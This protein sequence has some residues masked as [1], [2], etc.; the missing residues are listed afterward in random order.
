MEIIADELTVKKPQQHVQQISKINVYLSINEINIQQVIW[1]ICSILK[2][3]KNNERFI[4]T[5]NYDS[6]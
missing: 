6:V 1:D 3:L 4:K 2:C 5:L